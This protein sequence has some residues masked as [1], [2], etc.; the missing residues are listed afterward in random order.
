MNLRERLEAAAGPAD[1]LGERK[2]LRGCKSC[3]EKLLEKML[4]KMDAEAA[5]KRKE[6]CRLFRERNA[7][8]AREVAKKRRDLLR[9]T[10]SP[11]VYGTILKQGSC[12]N[13]TSVT[14][15]RIEGEPLVV[16]LA[17]CNNKCDYRHTDQRPS[18]SPV[19]PPTEQ[20]KAEALPGPPLAILTPIASPGSDSG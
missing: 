14:C 18:A 10:A 8:K 12:P 15:A 6:A 4:A 16:T 17:V 19:E 11:C 7:D 5:E 13:T 20:Q 1:N 9:G 2:D 3:K